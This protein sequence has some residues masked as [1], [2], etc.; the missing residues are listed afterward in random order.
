[1]VD[2]AKLDALDPVSRVPRWEAIIADL[3]RQEARGVR[4]RCAIDAA[5]AQAIGFATGGAAR[6]DGAPSNV[7]LWSLNVLPDHHGTGVA[8][9]LMNA[10]IGDGGAYLWVAT[11]NARAV[12]FYRKHG[13]EFDGAVQFDEEW[14]CH[15]SR[16][17]RPD[18]C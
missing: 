1:M 12:A 2:Q 13:F 7:Q 8:A 16:M 17:V 10:V 3:D 4:T 9:A 18:L 5:T 15:E 11:G 6:D 14:S